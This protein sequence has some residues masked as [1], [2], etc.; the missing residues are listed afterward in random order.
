MENILPF[1]IGA[2]IL[3]FKAYSNFQ[4]EQEKARQRDP[5][6]RPVGEVRAD[7]ERES[8]QPARRHTAEE[9]H[10][11]VQR[12]PREPRE[13]KSREVAQPIPSAYEKY[14][15]TW[16]EVE[17]V[18]RARGVHQP[19]GHAFQRLASY[20]KEEE[21]P[22]AAAEFSVEDFDLRDAVIKSAILHRPYAD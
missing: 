19:H 10:A 15:G 11:E 13:S 20:S 1:V 4:K 22:A 9:R 12:M 7:F 5:G 16:S 14:T 3:G 8:D 17:E 2:L 21:Q 6:Q 18:R